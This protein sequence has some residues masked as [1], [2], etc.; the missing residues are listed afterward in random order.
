MI[1]IQTTIIGFDNKPVTVFSAYDPD[2][3][4][5]VVSR[6]EA[7]QLKRKPEFMVITNDSNLD[8]DSLFSESDLKP[9]INAYFSMRGGVSSDGK[10]ARIVYSDKAIRATPS[11]ET[12]GYDESGV[13]YRISDGVT[14]SQIAVLATALYCGTRAAAIETSLNLMDDFSD[15]SKFVVGDILTI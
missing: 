14:C 4:I 5:M 10:S 13:K 8:R 3:K 1:K 6:I 9:A 12:D 7:Y 2:S 11:I 15:L